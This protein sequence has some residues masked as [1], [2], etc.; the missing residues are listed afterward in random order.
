MDTVRYQ[1]VRR[2]VKGLNR[3]K[4]VQARKIDILCNDMV[5][6]HREFIEHLKPLTFS[7]TFYESILGCSDLNMLVDRV[8]ALIV[9][10]MPETSV[11]IFLLSGEG[12]ELHMSGEHQPIEVDAGSF[13]G[14]FT[15][16]VVTRLSGCG[17]VCHLADMFEMGLGPDL[18]GL[19][20]L[21][22]ASVPLSNFGRAFGFILVYRRAQNKLTS[23]ELA[24]VASIT[25]GLS[26]AINGFQTSTK[27]AHLHP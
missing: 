11:S 4:R 17:R 16:H 9:A 18:P 13:E 14:C 24:K 19:E 27:Q 12:Y 10:I 23:D 22:A 6:A 1:R 8:R 15:A 5:S 20:E 25:P 3:T 2:L 26:G 21:S 7:V